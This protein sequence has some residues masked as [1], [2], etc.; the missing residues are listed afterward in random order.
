[1]GVTMTAEYI[2]QWLLD[3]HIESGIDK[4]WCEGYVSA[5]VDYDVISEEAFEELL[6]LI[7][8]AG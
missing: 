6:E 2:W 1:M 4:P 5:L 7:V 8:N 3:T